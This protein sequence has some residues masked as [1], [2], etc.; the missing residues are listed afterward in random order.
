MMYKALIVTALA[1]VV[2]C[3]SPIAPSVSESHTV[4]VEQPLIE[5]AEVYTC[6]IRDAEVAAYLAA[7][8]ETDSIIV[9]LPSGE[10]VYV[11]WL[12]RV[13]HHSGPVCS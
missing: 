11:D 4:A 10:T 9:T 3:S 2:A 12:H 5:A 7:H 1:S 8:P 13:F 6:A